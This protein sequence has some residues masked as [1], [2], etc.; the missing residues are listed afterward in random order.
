MPRDPYEGR[1]VFIECSEDSKHER[2]RIK[3]CPHCDDSFTIPVEEFCPS[4]GYD[5]GTAFRAGLIKISDPPI[6]I[7]AGRPTKGC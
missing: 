4:C 7:E 6:R 3:Q 2:V 5:A 1:T